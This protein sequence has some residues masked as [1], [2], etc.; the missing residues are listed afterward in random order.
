MQLPFGFRISSRTLRTRVAANPHRS[1]SLPLRTQPSR[2]MTLMRPEARRHPVSHLG[3]CGTQVVLGSLLHNAPVQVQEGK[4]GRNI[5]TETI[6]L[7]WS[8]MLASNYPVQT[9]KI[10]RHK[11]D[12]QI[13]QKKQDG[14][15]GRKHGRQ[16]PSILFGQ[17][18]R[19][20]RPSNL[21]SRF[22]RPHLHPRVLRITFRVY[23]YIRNTILC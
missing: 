6:G 18:F 22:V 21:S 3:H 1:R 20:I 14:T 17:L 2:L 13:G 7:T 16:R 19:P 5:W 11:L 10:G 8:V 15:I 9:N 12:A 23:K 4:I